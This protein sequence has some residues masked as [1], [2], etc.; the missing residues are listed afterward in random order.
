MSHAKKKHE[1]LMQVKILYLHHPEGLTDI[2]IAKALD[3]D[4]TSAYRYRQELGCRIVAHG[5]YVYDPTPHD[6]ELAQLI[7]NRTS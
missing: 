6:I 2:E 3:I 5:K 4:P 7:M 1:K